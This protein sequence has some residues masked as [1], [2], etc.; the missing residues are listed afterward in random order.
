MINY[1]TIVASS[2]NKAG[3]IMNNA[4]VH[5]TNEFKK[6]RQAYPEYE[7]QLFIK[8]Y[9]TLNFLRLLKKYCWIINRLSVTSPSRYLGVDGS[10]T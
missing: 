2:T 4:P 1:L 8:Q 10:R 3:K 9:S 6:D 7:S 5:I